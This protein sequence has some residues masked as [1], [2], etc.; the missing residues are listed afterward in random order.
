MNVGRASQRLRYSRR[1]GRDVMNSVS[2][3]I[4]ITE[5]IKMSAAVNR[6]VFEIFAALELRDQGVEPR[7]HELEEARLR[8]RLGVRFREED[9]ELPLLDERFDRIQRRE[10]PRR[11]TRLREGL[12]RHQLLGL[13]RE[14]MND[15]ARLGEREVVLDERGHLSERLD[16]AV[17]VGLLL[18]GADEDVLVG[19]ADLLERPANANIPN[20]APDDRRDPAIR[21]D[22][23]HGAIMPSCRAARQARPLAAAPLGRV[24]VERDPRVLEPSRTS[25]I[26]PAGFLFT[27]TRASLVTGGAFGKLGPAILN[28]VGGDRSAG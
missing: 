21:I 3:S 12:L 4:R 16:G 6:S 11:H 26:S 10:H 9:V 27:S 2:K 18:G 15:G 5:P 13:L 28:L 8:R 25:C 17:L 14:V 1:T 22:F 20:D 7:A 24:V 23:D 19:K